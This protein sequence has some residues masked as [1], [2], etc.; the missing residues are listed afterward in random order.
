[1]IHDVD[2]AVQKLVVKAFDTMKE[3]HHDDRHLVMSRFYWKLAVTEV[4]R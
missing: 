4:E 2:H 3:C 1:M